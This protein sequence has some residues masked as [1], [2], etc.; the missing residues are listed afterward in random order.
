MKTLLYITFSLTFFQGLGQS[1]LQE[2]L[3]RYNTRSVPYISVEALRMFQQQGN[4]VVLDTRE[5]NEYEVSHIQNATFVG[6][7]DF[8]EAEIDSILPNKETPIVVYCSLGIRSEEIAEKLKKAGY[9]QV[10]NLYGGIFEWKNKG[11]PVVNSENQ[12]TDSIHGYSKS[13]SKWLH[14]G[15]IV[16][17]QE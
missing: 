5:R 11:Y 7:S 14:N 3:Q 2:L 13:W 6:F 12:P 9:T 4:R 16:I 10:E 17:D 15:I 1:A 8:S